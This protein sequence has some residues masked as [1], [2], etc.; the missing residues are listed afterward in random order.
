MSATPLQ[1]PVKGCG[2]H[3]ETYAFVSPAAA[4]GAMLDRVRPVGVEEVAL[5]EAAGRVLGQA[6][7]AD[8]DSPA[9]DVSA[10]DGYAVR[11]ADVG[12]GVLPIAGEVQIGRAS[13][14]ERV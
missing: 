4:L 14:R 1:R 6:V 7:I 10:M 11:V 2:G 5:A 9:A 12:L 13:C 3:G 8:R